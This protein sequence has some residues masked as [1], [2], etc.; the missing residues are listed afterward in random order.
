MSPTLRI[1][2]VAGVEI[3]INWS[4]LIIFGLIVWTLVADVFPAQN[5]GL[6]NAA[7]TAMGVTAA[8]LFFA[9]LLLHE[10]GH[11]FQAR[12]EGVEIDGIILWLFGGVARLK[13]EFPSAWSELRIALAGPA[14]SAVLGVAFLALAQVPNS[15]EQV[16]GVA[17]WLGYINVI[18]LAFNML[19]AVPLDG[20]RVLHALLW[21][22]TGSLAT[23]TRRAADL[24]RGFGFVLIGIGVASLAFGGW[25][26]GLWLALIGWFL[27][28]AAG[29]EVESSRFREAL[30]GF[31]V[32]DVMV[33]QPVTVEADA[34]LA[35]F[36]DV[37]AYAHRY[38][39]YPVMDDGQAV[40]LL[41]F[42]RVARI[43]RLEWERTHVR[44]CMLPLSR[45]PVVRADD[46]LLDAIDAIGEGGANRALVIHGDT[47]DGLLSMTDVLRLVAWRTAGRP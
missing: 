32:R 17:A 37:V 22:A 25:L 28:L 47:L 29:A 44:D 18:L 9:S 15:P 34:S 20:G 45:V 36:M 21:R 2:R 16:D 12:R 5:P 42:G 13:G 1:G 38:T 11:A 35:D 19:P 14:V 39:T 31:R 43:P 24:G 23:S 33:R 7:Y 46:R 10:L 26:S 41:P 30:A 27:L 40:G 8:L 6:G 3:G 4:W